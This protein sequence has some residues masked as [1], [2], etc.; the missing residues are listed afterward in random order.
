ML[1]GKEKIRKLLA[2]KPVSIY[3]VESYYG[4]AKDARS[5]IGDFFEDELF[6]ELKARDIEI[7]FEKS[8]E[9]LLLL[10]PSRE[11]KNRLLTE[12]TRTLT[13]PHLSSD[14]QKI[15]MQMLA[16]G[17]IPSADL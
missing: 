2:Q 16:C 17:E 10:L 15:Y 13:K 8:G 14:D 11:I 12:V 9:S 1:T 6:S 5:L 3:I 7:P 4:H